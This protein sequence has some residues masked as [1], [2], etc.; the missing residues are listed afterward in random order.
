MAA[1]FDFSSIRKT[2]TKPFPPKVRCPQSERSQDPSV[3]SRQ[4]PG[5][6]GQGLSV[7]WGVTPQP[8]GPTQKAGQPQNGWSTN[9][10]TPPPP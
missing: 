5:N 2:T 8:Q 4:Y 6:G 1:I 10:P 9:Q 7:G 3:V